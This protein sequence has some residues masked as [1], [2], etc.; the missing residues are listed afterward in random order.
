MAQIQ[1]KNV[2]KNFDGESV[3]ERLNITIK[4]GSF[5]VLVG[6]SGC[7]KTTTLRM[8]AGLEE[9]SEGEIWIGDHNVSDISPGKRDVAMVFQNY[10]LY[11]T[12]SVRE[13]IEFGLTN[14]KIPKVER[15][16]L[17][18][19][20]AEIV[21]LTPY[22]S[23]KPQQLS[24]G[25]RQRVALARAMVKKPKV[26]LMDEPL[27]N[28]DAK[29]RQ[30]MRMELIQLHKRLGTTFIYVTHDQVEAM[31]MGEDVILMNKGKVV[32]QAGPMELYNEPNSMFVS[33]FVGMPPMNVMSIEDLVTYSEDSWS[34]QQQGVSYIG[35]RPE[36]IKLLKAPSTSGFCLNCEI[37]NRETLGAEIIY[38]LKSQ[39]GN[40]QGKSYLTPMVNEKKVYVEVEY[41]DLYY[42]DK[43]GNRISSIIRTEM[44]STLTAAGEKTS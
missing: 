3:I 44:K 16:E 37:I 30:Q 41:S 12:M 9:Q 21:G 29:L 13:N 35:F 20:I 28:L 11:P 43:D 26:F 31:S 32:Q 10:A 14:R 18:Y 40:I 4:D 17:V 19:E 25:Q 42:F 33:Q 36:K 24:G 34:F 6:P 15:K 27:S 22:L 5:T 38:Q 2:S 1:L 23:K 39:I 8:I 7:G